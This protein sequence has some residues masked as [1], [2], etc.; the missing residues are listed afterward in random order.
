MAKTPQGPAPEQENHSYFTTRAVAERLGWN[1]SQVAEMCRQGLIKAVKV[2]GHWRIPQEEAEKLFKFGP[3]DL[4]I[5][6]V[7][8]AIERSRM[9]RMAKGKATPREAFWFGLGFGRGRYAIGRLLI[10]FVKLGFLK[11]LKFVRSKGY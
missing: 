2:K 8:S 6:M 1:P 5:L 4:R 3:L 9:V 11:L 10:L 7:K